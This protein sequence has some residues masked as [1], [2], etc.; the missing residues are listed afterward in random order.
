MFGNI[1]GLISTWSFL[2]RDGPHYPIGNGINLAA[3]AM[4]LILGTLTLLWMRR[5][6]RRRAK[7]SVEDELAGLSAKQ[8]EDLD[9]KH[10]EFRWVA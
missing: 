6:N 3:A 8:I 9:W 4:I 1:G 7:S 2:K 10:P 5:D